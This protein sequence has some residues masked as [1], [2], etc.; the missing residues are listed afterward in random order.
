MDDSF[1]CTP[2]KPGVSSA[3]CKGYCPGT[4]HRCGRTWVIAA[5]MGCMALFERRKQGGADLIPLGQAI[6]PGSLNSLLS[7]LKHSYALKRFEQLLLV[8]KQ[9]DIGWISSLLPEEL[10]HCLVAEIRYPLNADWWQETPQLKQLG[11]ALVTL[12]QGGVPK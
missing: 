12:L 8:G 2:R 1:M 6:V 4:C 7:F 11:N 9:S 10:Q 3:Q 5:S